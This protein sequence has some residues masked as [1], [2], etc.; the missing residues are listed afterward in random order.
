MDNKKQILFY[1]TLFSTVQVADGVLTGIGVTA[2]GT[3][4][5]G[6]VLLKAA[7]ENFGCW[8]AIICT[9]IVAISAIVGLVW[10]SNKLY[11]AKHMMISLCFMYIFVAIIPWVFYL[12][13][14]LV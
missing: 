14:Y 13:K 10:I 5:E 12:Q 6:N 3:Q 11:W 1:A 2:F 8:E 9:K 4:A 7:I